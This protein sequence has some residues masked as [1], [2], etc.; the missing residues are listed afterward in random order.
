MILMR[1]VSLP[2][3]AAMTAASCF[4]LHSRTCDIFG[5]DSS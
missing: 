2:G 5:I 4:V 3:P 1:A